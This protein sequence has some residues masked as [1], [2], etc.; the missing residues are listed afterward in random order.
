[1]NRQ[2]VNVLLISESAGGSSFLRHRLNQRGC[3]CYV[4][5]SSAE[6]ARLFAGDEFEPVLC[7][8]W[9]E[10]MKTLISVLIG[11]G[12][13]LLRSVAVENGCWWLPAIRYGKECIG[14]PALRPSEFNLAIDK[15]VEEI[16]SNRRFAAGLSDWVDR[17][18]QSLIEAATP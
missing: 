11:S 14:A 7:T 5:S 10:G 2:L 4:A 8:S 13:S 3:Q 18:E 6:A 12:A 17:S 16:K 15:I 1:M 9:M